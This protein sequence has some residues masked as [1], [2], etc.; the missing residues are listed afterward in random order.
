MI[1]F[2]LNWLLSAPLYISLA[3]A[4]EEIEL[5]NFIWEKKVGKIFVSH[6]PNVIFKLPNPLIFTIL[7]H[8]NQKTQNSLELGF[9]YTFIKP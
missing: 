2:L 4:Q 9:E 7:I 5:W 8:I 3:K 1:L 6:S